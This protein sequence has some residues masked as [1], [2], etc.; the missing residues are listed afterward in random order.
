MPTV[1]R[2]LARFMKPAAFKYVVASSLEHALAA[3]AE[4]GDEAKF[5]AGGQSLL[6][7]MNFR[8][9]QPAV[10]IDLNPL[11][12]LAYIAHDHDEVRIGA[13]TRNRQ[14]EHDIVFL[15][16][17]PLFA[18]ALPLIAHPQIR[19][20][21]TIGGNLSHA[22]PASE[23]PAL[24][25][26]MQARFRLRSA[27]NA[28]EIAAADFFLG[29]LTTDIQ[30]TEMLVEI[31]FP[32]PK[33]NTGSAFMEISRRR[34]DYAIAGVAATLTVDEDGTCSEARLALCGV[35]E[36][37][38][39]GSDAV[40]ALIGQ[41]VTADSIAAVVADVRDALTPAGSVHATADYQ[42]HIAGVLTRR[43]L[44]QAHARASHAA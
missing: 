5:L 29:L 12:D 4:Y 28:R 30:D 23:M 13:L 40:Q 32:A 38:V 9:A 41:A 15:K 16:R 6:P 11:L 34:G 44:A 2:G 1:T 3:K 35:G 43:V 31:V 42:R 18:D 22:D 26:A 10:L 33:P 17:C 19:N 21:G 7:A 14:L 36:T 37:P 27:T 20:R 24:A 8:L 25:L 39:D